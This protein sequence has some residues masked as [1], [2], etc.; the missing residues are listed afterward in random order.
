MIVMN[1]RSKQGENKPEYAQYESQP[2]SLTDS[3]VITY[4]II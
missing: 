4:T 1:I 2:L 3:I